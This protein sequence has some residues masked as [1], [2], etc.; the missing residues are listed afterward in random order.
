MAVP[1][2]S[3]FRYTPDCQK[4][5]RHGRLPDA[6]YAFMA[7][8]A[9]QITDRDLEILREVSLSRWLTRQQLYFLTFNGR[10]SGSTLRRRVDVLSRLGT[11]LAVQWGRS[12][13]D[14]GYRSAYTLGYNGALLLR[15]YYGRNFPWLPGQTR[16]HL[17]RILAVLAANELRL[18]LQT[19]LG[20]RLGRWEITGFRDGPVAWFRLDGQTIVLEVLRDDEQVWDWDSL[21]YRSWSRRPFA[22]LVLAQD[23][24]EALKAFRALRRTVPPERLLF[25]TDERAFG[26]E[27]DAVGTVWRWLDERGTS[28]EQL[29]LADPWD[30]VL[31]A[32]EDNDADEADEESA[33]RME[34]GLAVGDGEAGKDVAVEGGVELEASGSANGR[35]PQ[36]EAA[37]AGLDGSAAETG[38]SGM[39]GTRIPGRPQAPETAERER[40]IVWRRA[41][42]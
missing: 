4:V 14:R 20:K 33:G 15:H 22:L 32:A 34:R 38:T 2:S 41:R 16:I 37:D 7:L 3:D 21:R 6:G 36:T 30:E 26:A 29:A 23:E 28:L 13:Q 9:G 17:A 5:V 11:L 1:R 31:P 40:V 39:E 27:P 24:Q 8:E 35:G 12:G 19:A 10:I 42:A 18:Q 25:S